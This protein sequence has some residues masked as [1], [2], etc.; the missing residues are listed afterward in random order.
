MT[1]RAAQLR[2]ATAKRRKARRDAGE[3]PKER[4]AH[5]D[6]WS[7]LDRLFTDLAAKRKT[8][9]TEGETE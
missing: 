1:D 4:W 3:V 9:A 2:A 6:D 5:P 7:E 8:S